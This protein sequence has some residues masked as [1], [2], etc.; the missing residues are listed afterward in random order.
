MPMNDA[1][2]PETRPVNRPADEGQAARYG[3]Q[4]K[5]N[6]KTLALVIGLH[7][8]VGAGLISAFAPD[9]PQQ[10]LDAA[11]GALSV[12]ITTPPEKLPPPPSPEPEPDEGAQ[13]DPGREAVP[14]PVTQP[15]PKIV[16]RPDPPAPKATSTGKANTSGANDSGDG[17][18][19]AGSGDGTGSGNAGSGQGGGAIASGPSV[20]SG[21]IDSARDF[22]IPPGG[23]EVRFGTQVI[24]T[25]TVGVD[26]RASGCSIARAG[27]D[28][29]TNARVCPLVIE[30]IRF[31][32]AVNQRGE[33]VPA[34][35][36]WRQV[37]DA[38]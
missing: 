29:E 33:K 32:P 5:W 22:P 30:R 2:S 27:P 11:E 4:K 25:F 28:P 14:Q 7:L 17:T 18:G 12:T 6:L 35:Y 34:R 26:G 37:F 21:S 9:L 8:V 24:V 3:T 31:N 36:A 20:R 16:T 19:A 15:S 38:R 23:R 10:A 13:G 1:P